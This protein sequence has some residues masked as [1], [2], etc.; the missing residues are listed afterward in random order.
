MTSHRLAGLWMTTALFAPTLTVAQSLSDEPLFLGT[1]RIQSVEAQALL[2]NDT[3]TEE[4]IEERNPTTLAD[5]FAGETSVIATGGAAV[6]Q[7]VFVNGLEESLLSVTID[8]A[9][10]NK[11]AFHHH[12]NVLLDP[13]LL[14]RVEVSRGLAPADAGPNAV[15]GAIAYETKDVADLLDDGDNFGGQLKL[16]YGSNGM[17]L[18]T[19]LSI[20]G[21][22]GGFEYLLSGTKRQGEDYKDGDGTTVLGTNAELADYL[23]KVAYES[24]SGHR[25]EF[26]A[27]STL[28]TGERATQ[29]TSRGESQRPNFGGLTAL[30][31]YL[32]EGRSERKSYTLTYTNEQATGLW[33]PT[34]QLSYNEQEVNARLVAGK[35]KSL[36]GTAKNE[37]DIG[38]GTVTAGFDFFKEEAIAVDPDSGDEG[39]KE[40][41]SSY[42]IFAQVRQDVGDRL[43][44]SYGAR[45]DWQEFTGHSGEKFYDDGA[46]VNGSV[47]VML[48][49]AW[50]LN[51]GLAS[52]WGGYELGEAALVGNSSWTYDGFQSSRAHAGR[53]GLRFEQ[54]GWTASAA[55]FKTEIHDLARVL[56]GRGTT[57]GTT[58]DVLSE[59][60]DLSLGYDWGTGYVQ[61]NYTDAEVTE[62]GDTIGTQS[63]YRGRPVGQA[64]ALQAAWDIT[65]EYSI[66]GSA[67]VSFD[68]ELDDGSVVKG[69][70]VANIYGT[71]TPDQMENLEL[72]LDIRNVFDAT[73]SRRAA[74]GQNNDSIVALT[75]PG[76]T[77][78]LTASIKF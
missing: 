53:I 51:A 20:Y 54:G 18:G 10:Q 56:P 24:A 65:S 62:D 5:V 67:E 36:S 70:E 17:G 58:N 28:D 3:I 45:Y 1:L 68:N 15:A 23:G 38:N 8:G 69:Y 48:S 27:S 60:Y 61:A 33:D 72:R 31:T 77:F 42:G 14:K 13:G 40:K 47:D 73:Y 66:G 9:R 26:A 32:K 16:S 64:L 7:K 4:E 43:S 55:Y 11:G 49:D 50:T 71:Y 25:L 76:R 37:F 41:L 57:R 78:A 74:D 75:E 59:G 34:L 22:E 29:E 44:F 6:A 30:D 63:Y 52:T 39:A 46:S 2:G 12:G 19:I 35:N 21:R